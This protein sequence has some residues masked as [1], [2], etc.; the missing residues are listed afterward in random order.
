[1]SNTAARGEDLTET[2]L[3]QWAFIECAPGVR[4]AG[5]AIITYI[6]AEGYLRTPLEVIQQESKKPLS[7]EDLEAGAGTEGLA[8]AI[9]ARI[10]AP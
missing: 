7:L 8:E 2:L 4:T 3:H 10:G 9:R 5:E 1:M 6:D